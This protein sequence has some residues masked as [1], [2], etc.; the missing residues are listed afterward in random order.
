M[1]NGQTQIKYVETVSLNNKIR[2]NTSCNPWAT[3][4]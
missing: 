3:K 2:L 4:Y 1:M